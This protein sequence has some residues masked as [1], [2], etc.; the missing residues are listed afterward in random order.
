[1]GLFLLF[2]N[3]YFVNYTYLDFFPNSPTN[4][5]RELPP[6]HRARRRELIVFIA[7]PCAMDSNSDLSREKIPL[8]AL[9]HSAT[10]E[11]TNMMLIYAILFHFPNSL[12]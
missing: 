7:T 12:G 11:A 3:A 8:T 1:M 5:D 6:N 10:E 9:T 4:D 2:P